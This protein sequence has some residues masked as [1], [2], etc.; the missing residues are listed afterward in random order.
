MSEKILEYPQALLN[1]VKRVAL[2]AG[3]ST[4]EY[5]DESGAFADFDSKDDGSPVTIAD[6]TAHDII[7]KGLKNITP[8]ISII[9]EEGA[10][11]PEEKAPGR[12]A[13]VRLSRR[14]CC[15]H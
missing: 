6:Q 12:V 5:F 3:D 1:Q 7:L 8:S 4:L 14:C 10:G 15:P 11:Q 9:S 2:E 13:P